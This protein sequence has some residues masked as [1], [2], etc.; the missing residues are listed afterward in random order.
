VKWNE[1]TVGTCGLGDVGAV[2]G[3]THPR[4]LAELSRRDAECLFLVPGYGAQGATAADVKAAFLPKASAPWST[5][6]R[7]HFPLPSGRPDWESK[8]RYARRRPP[9]N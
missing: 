3:A 8:I 1:P 5:F 4:E 2:V 6:P 7:R 9:R